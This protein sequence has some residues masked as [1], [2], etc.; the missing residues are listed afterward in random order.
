MVGVLALGVSAQRVALGEARVAQWALVGL[1][2]GVD[3]LVALELARLPEALGTDRAHIV[4]LA[5]VD[6]FVSL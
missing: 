4:P 3:T 1:L 6:V 2:S 5:R